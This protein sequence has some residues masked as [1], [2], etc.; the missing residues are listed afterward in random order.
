MFQPLLFVA[1]DATITQSSFTRQ[2]HF[3]GDDTLLGQVAAWTTLLVLPPLA[4]SALE[5]RVSLFGIRTRGI[6]CVFVRTFVASPLKVD[7]CVTTGN[8][9]C[10][11]V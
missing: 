8:V 5:A 2:F 9:L 10:R 4:T 1:Y 6:Q 7:A 3:F 11:I